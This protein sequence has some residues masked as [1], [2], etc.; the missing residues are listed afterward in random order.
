[1][2]FIQNK[3]DDLWGKAQWVTEGMS[4]GNSKG[5]EG[6]KIW[7]FMGHNLKIHRIIGS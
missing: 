3:Q 2:L 6:N 1:M 4:G 7:D 5:S